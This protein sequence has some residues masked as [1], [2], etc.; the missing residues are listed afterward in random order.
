MNINK[1]R[2]YTPSVKNVNIEEKKLKIQFQRTFSLAKKNPKEPCPECGTIIAEFM[3]KPLSEVPKHLKKDLFICS[4]CCQYMAGP[5]AG[6]KLTPTAPKIKHPRGWHLLKCYV[7]SEKNYYEFGVEKPE[8]KGLHEPTLKQKSKEE[9]VAKPKVK[10]LNKKM[11]VRIQ[12]S[13]AAILFDLKRMNVSQFDTKK[14]KKF[15]QY[16]KDITL[17]ASGDKISKNYQELLD[18]YEQEIKKL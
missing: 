9:Q 11:K 17:L 18:K 16:L 14:K 7:D 1:K 3:D 12:H 8:L 2:S 10:K 5:P 13:A 4:H 15:D 6:I